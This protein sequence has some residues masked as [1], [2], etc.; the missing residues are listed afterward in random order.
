MDNWTT[1][2]GSNIWYFRSGFLL[3]AGPKSNTLKTFS[4]KQKWVEMSGV[5]VPHFN[6]CNCMRHRTVWGRTNSFL[7][8]SALV[9]GKWA[10]MPKIKSRVHRQL[11]VDCPWPRPRQQE[12]MQA[13]SG[14][15]KSLDTKKLGLEFDESFSN[16]NASNE[17]FQKQGMPLC[18]AI[19]L[20]W[21]FFYRVI[22]DH[23]GEG[24]K[25]FLSMYRN[26]ANTQDGLS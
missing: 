10:Q 20:H 13:S 9:Q 6:M 12:C 21:K 16:E 1:V 22:G 18:I 2:L 11:Y 14:V 5:R 24:L 17:T 23:A 15:W 8:W 25:P 3:C 26:R 4:Q 19:L 7:V